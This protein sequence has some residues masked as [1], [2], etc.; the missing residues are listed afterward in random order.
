MFLL[1]KYKTSIFSINRLF[2]YTK[3]VSYP[4]RSFAILDKNNSYIKK[5]TIFRFNNQKI[6]SKKKLN[7]FFLE[8]K[9]NRNFRFKFVRPRSLATQSMKNLGAVYSLNRVDKRKRAYTLTY[10]KDSNVTT[11]VNFFFLSLINYNYDKT[12]DNRP[13]DSSSKNLFSVKV[14]HI[15]FY[16]TNFFLLN[17]TIH[18]SSLFLIEN[19]K[20]FNHLLGI[21]FRK[22]FSNGSLLN[23]ENFELSSQFFSFFQNKKINLFF[24]KKN[25]IFSKKKNLQ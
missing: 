22:N 12:C 17:F 5:N 24:Y 20:S 16:T 23:F 4:I 8:K 18:L 1:N 2:F 15:F 13:I 11:S 6:F 9:Y 25:K 3:I 7:K 19:L 14:G 10:I 21:I